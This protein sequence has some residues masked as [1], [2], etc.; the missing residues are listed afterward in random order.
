MLKR[1]A[2]T[3]VATVAMLAVALLTPLVFAAYR[4]AMRSEPWLDES[5]DKQK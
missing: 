3:A 1:I 2:D 5:L 4:E